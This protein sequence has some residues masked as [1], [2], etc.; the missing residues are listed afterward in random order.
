M[1]KNPKVN[2]GKEQVSYARILDIKRALSYEG[3]ENTMCYIAWELHCIEILE[4]YTRR[5]QASRI[6]M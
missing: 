6:N 1:Q 2:E 4:E 5:A 3:E